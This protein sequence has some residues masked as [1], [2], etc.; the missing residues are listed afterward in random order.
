[1]IEKDMKSKLFTFLDLQMGKLSVK[2][3]VRTHAHFRVSELKS[4]AL[5]RSANLTPLLWKTKF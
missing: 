5:D 2:C 1:M 4:D 3:G